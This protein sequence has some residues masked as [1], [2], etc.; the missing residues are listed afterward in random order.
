MKITDKEFADF[1]RKSEQNR[2]VRG[3]LKL[4]TPDMADII[5]VIVGEDKPTAVWN[6]PA[7]KNESEGKIESGT[8]AKMETVPAVQNESEE[9]PGDAEP[10]AAEDKSLDDLTK[11]YAAKLAAGSKVSG[12]TE[13]EKPFRIPDSEKD[14]ICRM[15]EKGISVEDIM[16][17]TGRSR[18]SVK[19]ILNARGIK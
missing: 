18:I 3:I 19:K 14:E 17:Q 8:L 12:K 2:I 7:G 16:A 6:V 5:C 15:K 1:I 13:A 9:F 11:E 10:A 4:D